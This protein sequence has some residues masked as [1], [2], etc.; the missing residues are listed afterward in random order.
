[1]PNG[2]DDR[3]WEIRIPKEQVGQR[4]HKRDSHVW[5]PETR[6]LDQPNDRW[7]HWQCK[8]AEARRVPS[9]CVDPPVIRI[10]FFGIGD[11]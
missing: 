2:S 5:L 10:L 8:V 6:P 9:A 11:D 4:V 7:W 1:M 3:V